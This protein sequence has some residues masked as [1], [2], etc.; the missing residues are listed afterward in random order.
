MT[1]PQPP[2]PICKAYLVCDRVVDDP[3]TG[4]TSLVGLPRACGI[5]HFPAAVPLGVFAR[6]TASRG[7]Y[8][9]EVQLQDA[10]GTVHWRDGPPRIWGM[11]DPLELYDLK[12]NLLV[13]F[14]APGTY[15]IVLVLNGQEV[16]RHPFHAQALPQ[17][18]QE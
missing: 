4:D 6:L 7:R 13:V 3:A 9:I 16:A 15:D 11:A 8:Q 1:N 17:Q 14:P 2:P 12:L 5:R 10:D 18:A